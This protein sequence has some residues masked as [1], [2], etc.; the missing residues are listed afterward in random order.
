M[1]T[2]LKSCRHETGFTLVELLVVI[3][4][5]SVLAALLIP[6]VRKALEKGRNTVCINNVRQTGT[7]FITLSFEGFLD[8]PPGTAPGRKGQVTVRGQPWRYNWFRVVAIELGFAEQA[9]TPGPA[10][11]LSAE[12][13]PLFLCP[14]KDESLAGWAESNLSYGI[15]YHRFGPFP[16]N[17]AR[18]LEDAAAT[19]IIGDSNDDNIDDYLIKDDNASRLPSTRHNN[20]A[21]AYFGDGHFGHVP[22]EA[23]DTANGPFSK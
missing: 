5:I 11:D 12:K 21:N 15:N 4:I 23:F 10:N 6:V 1:R 22:E 14:S 13:P 18:I 20:G 17:L 3:G 2:S 19:A 9:A 16:E 8:F 7:G